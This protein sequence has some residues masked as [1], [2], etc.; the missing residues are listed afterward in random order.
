[1]A[2]KSRLNTKEEKFK[3]NS[4]SKLNLSR[5]GT[6]IE[7]FYDRTWIKQAFETVELRTAKIYR[8]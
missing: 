2:N 8:R 3:Q 4:V 7:D 6:G 5:F 1:V